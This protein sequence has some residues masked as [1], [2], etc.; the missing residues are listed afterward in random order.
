M[1][2]SCPL[3]LLIFWG[4]LWVMFVFFVFSK[5]TTSHAKATHGQIRTY[6]IVPA[7]LVW[8]HVVGNLLQETGTGPEWVQNHLHDLGVATF[9]LA[10]GH[11]Y[12]TLRGRRMLNFGYDPHMARMIVW[13]VPVAHGVGTLLCVL[14]KV[15]QVTIWRERTIAQGYS[16]EFDFGDVTAFLIGFAI[17]MANQ[18]IFDRRILR[19][20]AWYADLP[21]VKESV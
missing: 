20:D 13:F 7:V 19:H 18:A 8:V 15:G 4:A 3:S 9:A 1:R 5:K 2:W 10:H 14:Y 12:M 17:V 21:R 11:T 6:L 16:G